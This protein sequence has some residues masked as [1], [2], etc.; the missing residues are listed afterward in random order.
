MAESKEEW[1]IPIFNGQQGES[2]RRWKSRIQWVAAGTA[3]DKLNLLAPRVIQKFRGEP[4]EFFMEKDVSEFRKPNGLEAL[5][6]LLDERYGSIAEIE[7]TAVVNDFFYKMRRS[8]GESATS[9][10]ARYRTQAARM[11]KVIEAEMNK[12][13]QLLQDLEVK[14]YREELWQYHLD[15]NAHKAKLKDVTDKRSALQAILRRLQATPAQDQA[16]DHVDQE[17]D[18][19]NQIL[20]LEDPTPPGKPRF[21]PKPEKVQFKLPQVLH[22]TLF[23][24]MFGLNTS[25]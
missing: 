22:G 18:L 2:Y 23:M 15:M 14:K 25:V 17:T 4:A 20:Q 21:P 5:Y 8:N 7:L 10:A 1:Q 13:S 19:M 11:E 9:F 6:K 3:D 16:P 24:N 12:E